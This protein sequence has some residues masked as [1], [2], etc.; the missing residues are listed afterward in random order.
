LARIEG[1]PIRRWSLTLLFVA[2][3]L[4][5]G[6]CGSNQT[7]EQAIKCDQFKQLPDGTWS[8]TTDVKLAYARD[9]LQL[10]GYH[11]KGRYWTN[12]TKG[13]IITS[14]DSEDAV[15]LAALDKKCTIKQ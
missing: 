1:V 15:V 13:S 11:V 7:L 2:V 8:A 6:G 5:L 14:K 12:Y 10:W 3:S 9:G 4:A